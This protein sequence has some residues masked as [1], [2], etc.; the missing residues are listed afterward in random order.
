MLRQ[1]SKKRLVECVF[2]IVLLQANYLY[3]QTE[4]R[5]R[6]VKNVSDIFAE[7]FVFKSDQSGKGRVDIYVQVPYSGIKFVNEDERYIGRLEVSATI[8]MKEQQLWQK[9]QMVELSVKDFSQTASSKHSNTKQFSVDL[10]PGE[11]E[12]VLQVTDQGSKK[13]T[14]LRKPLVVKD[15]SEDSLA[16]SDIMLVSRVNTKGTKKEIVPNLTGIIGRESVSFY[17][18]FE[19]YNRVQ[20]DSIQLLCKFINS[21]QEEVMKRMKSEMLSEGQTQIVWQI[22]TPALDADQY[23]LK[24]EATGYSKI[25]PGTHFHATVSRRF[26]VQIKDLPTTVT[27]IDNAI[28]QLMYIA[29]GSEISFIRESATPEEKQKRFLE[30]WAKR[31]PDPKTSENEL[32]EEYYS[33]VDYAN[34]NFS[35]FMEGWKTDMGMI[36]IRFGTPENIERYPFNAENKPYEI[37]YYYNLNREFVFVDETGFGDYRLRYPTTDLWGRVR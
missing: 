30:F 32:M 11:C 37:W 24:V 34:K 13:V 5:D 25:Y 4:E 7:A 10:P 14:T 20:L 15:F 1:T 16:L 3:S 18:F 6:L 29:K 19:A 17:L 27:N 21:N 12:L 31:D 2:L 9:N 36:L 22:D 8:L 23:V 26:V 33:R 28:D 35:T